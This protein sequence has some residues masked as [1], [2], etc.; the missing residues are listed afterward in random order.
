MF[1]AVALAFGKDIMATGSSLFQVCTKCA[2]VLFE[3][4]TRDIRFTAC[5]C[6]HRQKMW[7]WTLMVDDPSGSV[8]TSPTAT[9]A[10][11]WL[12]VHTVDTSCMARERVDDGK[13]ACCRDCRAVD[14]LS[15]EHCSAQ[16]MIWKAD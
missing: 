3:C 5:V 7:R 12:L 8:C 2:S 6:R 1:V 16:N 14:V 9:G 4:I 13:D 15:A 11:V 10:R